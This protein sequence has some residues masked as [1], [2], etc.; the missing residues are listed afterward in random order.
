MLRNLALRTLYAL[1]MI[2]P[3]ALV[4]WHVQR[5]GMSTLTAL[6]ALCG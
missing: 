1:H 4:S 2:A 5:L 6:R 3:I